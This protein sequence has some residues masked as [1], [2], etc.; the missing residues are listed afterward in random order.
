MFLNNEG[1]CFDQELWVF[2]K[3]RSRW[4]SVVR[5]VPED[6]GTNRRYFLRLGFCRAVLWLVLLSL[7]HVLCHCFIVSIGP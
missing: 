5:A 7:V 1:F 2:V 6:V 3:R 4:S